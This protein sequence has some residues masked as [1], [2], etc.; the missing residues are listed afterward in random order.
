ML[1]VL[2]FIASAFPLLLSCSVGGYEE[3]E[4][5]YS[6]LRAD[7]CELIATDSGESAV[8]LADDG[9]ELRLYPPVKA[10]WLAKPDSSYRALLYY[11]VADGGGEPVAVS[12]MPVLVPSIGVDLPSDPVSFESAW[13]SG[14]YAN[15]AF[16]VKTGVADGVSPKHTIG[17]SMDSIS[18]AVPGDTIA[19]L[20]LRHDQG[21]TPGYYSQKVYA[22]IPLA[23]LPSGAVE[24]AVADM[25][26]G[27]RK[28]IF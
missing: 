10:D 6:L 19:H 15:V 12:R 14:K 5:E 26:G 28:I 2:V 8:A 23:T 9:A 7:F 25:D 17:V 1:R 21:G 22:S 27:L 13:R 3:G 18:V 20:S 4:G 11:K 16:Y 24:I